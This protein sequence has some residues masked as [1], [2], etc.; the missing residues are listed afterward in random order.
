MARKIRI[1]LPDMERGPLFIAPPFATFG[2]YPRNAYELRGK[3]YQVP[4]A[5]A[6]T[7]WP[8]PGTLLQGNPIDP[9]DHDPIIYAGPPLPQLVGGTGWARVGGQYPT[10]EEL[11]NTGGLAWR[12][13]YTD[14]TLR[15]IRGQILTDL[16]RQASGVS[17]YMSETRKPDGSALGT[18]DPLVAWANNPARRAAWMGTEELLLAVWEGYTVAGVDPFTAARDWPYPD[19]YF[20]VTVGIHLSDWS[21]AWNESGGNPQNPA[22]SPDPVIGQDAG[23]LAPADQTALDDPRYT[24]VPP[25]VPQSLGATSGL[26]QEEWDKVQPV[27]IGGGYEGY[28]GIEPILLGGDQGDYHLLPH[29]EPV[30]VT[31]PTDKSGTI[32]A[33][34]TTADDVGAA[35]SP[36]G[37]LGLPSWALWLGAAAIAVLLVKES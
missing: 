6:G 25:V 17:W 32:T 15:D 4:D 30:I 21:A 37:G 8:T 2:G 27:A 5:R 18:P 19:K 9:A 34:T 13:W 23:I 16:G 12:G 26:T 24:F 14:G 35:G 22:L 1:Y 10:T 20:D 7:T 36:N 29:G 3:L 11:G 33:T 31:G 28:G